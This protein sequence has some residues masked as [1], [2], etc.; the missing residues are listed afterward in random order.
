VTAFVYAGAA[1][2]AVVAVVTGFATPVSLIGPIITA[3]VLACG[4]AALT[5][6]RKRRMERLLGEIRSAVPEVATGLIEA[7]PE[8]VAGLIAEL[9]PLGFALMAVTDTS[10][11]GGRPIRTWIMTGEPWTTWVEV[12]MAAVPMAIFLSQAQTGRLLET[13]ARNALPIDH[14]RLL[15]QALD[16]TPALALDAHRA[17]LE[18]WTRASGSPRAVRTLDDY[19][20]VEAEQ[21][22]LTGGMR[23]A[24]FL[25]RVVDPSLRTWT[26]TAAIAIAT[27]LVVLVLEAI[28]A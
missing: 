8:A 3:T 15:V 2:A 10:I 5:F 28:R 12:G 13:T 14:P 25:E 7:P 9:R 4:L 23:M 6:V 22:K 27:L 21:R 19:L 16:T 26:I 1:I 17:T 11:G 20:A 24:A 18:E